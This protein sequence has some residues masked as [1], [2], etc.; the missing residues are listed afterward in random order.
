MVARCSPPRSR[1]ANPSARYQA[2][3]KPDQFRPLEGIG[4]DVIPDIGGEILHGL[5]RCRVGLAHDV[6]VEAAVEI[7]P[8]AGGHPLPAVLSLLSARK[9]GVSGMVRGGRTDATIGPTIAPCCLDQASWPSLG[10][11]PDG[12]DCAPPTLRAPAAR[13]FRLGCVLFGIRV[14]GLRHPA[15]VW[16]DRRILDDPRGRRPVPAPASVHGDR[17]SPS[18]SL[19][20]CQIRG[21]EALPHGHSL[22][23]CPHRGRSQ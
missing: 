8:T 16:R 2:H 1:L 18:R 20:N 17:A 9:S 12:S 10:L 3:P 7:A 11:R 14:I 23:D 21:R 19:R 22:A 15:L 13:H 4:C 5:A 6:L